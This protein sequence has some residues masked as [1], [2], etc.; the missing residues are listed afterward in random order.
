MVHKI[1][2]GLEYETCW[3]SCYFY[4]VAAESPDEEDVGG[5]VMVN[6][7]APT[8]GVP[9]VVVVT[10]WGEVVV[11]ESV[12]RAEDWLKSKIVELVEGF[13]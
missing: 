2:K 5:T 4:G 13:P 10:T 3:G 8:S 6:K 7:D 9:P 11:F 12:A 1:E